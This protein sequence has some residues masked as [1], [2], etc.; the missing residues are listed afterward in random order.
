[1]SSNL[2]LGIHNMA[3]SFKSKNKA[4]STK[5]KPSIQDLG[6]VPLTAYDRAKAEWATLT[7]DAV[8]NQGRFFVLAVL[9]LIAALVM[10]VALRGLTPLK[11]VVP[12]SI[13]V[14]QVTGE[15]RPVGITAT[16]FVPDQNQKGYFLAQWAKKMLA[17]DPFTTERDL[18]DAYRMIRGKAIEEFRAFMQTTQ[19]IVRLRQDQSLTRTINLNSLT[20]IDTNIAQI[21]AIA[22]E[23]S[24]TA[25]AAPTK[26][27]IVTV[28]FVLDPPKTEREIL[29]NPLGMFITHFAISE[30][31]G[32]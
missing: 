10:A 32:Q 8:V 11:T 24:A 17:L 14:D 29:E 31:F 18:T 5:K 2:Q 1:M 30:E 16:R 20:F 19:P 3:L 7:G 6:N 21:R 9:G 15:S 28:H 26:R 23:R 13:E 12:Y 27:Y 4:P 25:S 22:Q